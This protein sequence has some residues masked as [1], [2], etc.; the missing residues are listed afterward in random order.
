MPP[1]PA[2]ELAEGLK[3]TQTFLVA[4]ATG[5]IGKRLTEVLVA[6]GHKVIALT[7]SPEKAN[8]PDKSVLL[9]SDLSSISDDTEISSIVNLA[10]ESIAAA[11][12][13]PKQKEKIISSRVDMTNNLVALMKRLKTIPESFIN[14]SATG[15]YGMRGDELLKEDDPGM[16]CFTHEVCLKREQASMKAEEL[17]VRTVNLRIG[18]VVGPDGGA[19]E[20]M[21]PAFRLGLG[22]P[23][24]D[25]RQWMSWIERDDMV[26]L[27]IHSITNSSLRG[28]VN[29]VSPLAV[30]NNDFARLL[31]K[32]LN[33][34]ALLRM[35]G[36]VLQIMFSELAR[37]ILL[38]GQR[39]VPEK[40]VQSGF[41]FRFSALEDALD[42]CFSN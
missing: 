40:A 17:D 4:G 19:L 21:L 18:L 22:G 38:R 30:R 9:I 26:R 15:W 24:G 12:W 25:G 14:A 2:D 27:I 35:P 1:V 13:T 28:P 31:G 8:L 42:Y 6:G 37:E 11:R 5:F 34:P 3:G 41:E 32:A 7:R 20:K 16:D 10:G 39:V 36:W 33:R 29:A 23:L